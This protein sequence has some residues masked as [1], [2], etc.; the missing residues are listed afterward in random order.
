MYGKKFSLITDHQPLT[1]I[2][3]PK[4]GIPALA[5]ARMQRWAVL[6]SAYDYDIQYRSSLNNANADL[7]SRL[8]YGHPSS[9]DPEEHFVCASVVDEMP[10]TADEIADATSKDP[11]LAKVLEY[12]LSGWPRGNGDPTLQPYFTRKDELSLDDGCIMWGRR[13][14]VPPKFQKGIL[15]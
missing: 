5:A 4:S 7:L 14:V 15:N 8:P 3:G 11:T 9:S 1:R 6:L 12:T 13:V 10:I 2:F